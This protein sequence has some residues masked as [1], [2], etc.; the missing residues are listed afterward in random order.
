MTSTRQQHSPVLAIL[1]L[2]LLLHTCPALGLGLPRRD[3]FYGTA[4][5]RKAATAGIALSVIAL[6]LS[7]VAFVLMLYSRRMRA[8]DERYAVRA[9]ELG[10]V[11]G[12]AKSG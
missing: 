5:N 9:Q 12:E 1:L 10:A 7:I 6:V 8:Q 2:G 4:G 11:E 3:S